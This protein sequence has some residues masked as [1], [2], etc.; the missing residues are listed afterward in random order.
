MGRFGKYKTLMRFSLSFTDIS[1][2]M[3]ICGESLFRLQRVFFWQ[4]CW[5]PAGK[6]GSIAVGRLTVPFSPN[7][8]MEQPRILSLQWICQNWCHC[9]CTEAKIWC[10][11]TIP[12]NCNSSRCFTAVLGQVI[13]TYSFPSKQTNLSGW[14]SPCFCSF[15]VI[16]HLWNR[17]SSL[18]CL[19]ARESRQ[20]ERSK[21]KLA[22]HKQSA[23][24]RCLAE[25]ESRIQA[26]SP[27]SGHSVWS[28]DRPV[29]RRGL[30]VY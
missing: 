2:I 25:T 10:S 12:G 4:Y 13:V 29:I 30:H 18:E 3:V 27:P 5:F 9:A 1:C 24:K 23:F 6:I 7:T 14:C 20:E 28:R 15:L 16:F 22:V 11:L 19:W 8:P 17:Y 21:G 26:R